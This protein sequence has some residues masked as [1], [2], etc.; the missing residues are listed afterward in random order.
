LFF[1][2]CRF[3]GFLLIRLGNMNAFVIV[4]GGKLQVS[5]LTYRFDIFRF[6][7]IRTLSFFLITFSGSSRF[8]NRFFFITFGGFLFLV[9]RLL[10]RALIG[11][12]I[13]FLLRVLIG[14]RSRRF[15]I[16]TNNSFLHLIINVRSPS[17][18]NENLVTFSFIIW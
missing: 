1:F 10:A 15:S 12:L 3:I 4:F 9:D 6:Y 11:P 18:R 16:M 14:I 2:N 13:R 7:V 17:R 5:I 8:V